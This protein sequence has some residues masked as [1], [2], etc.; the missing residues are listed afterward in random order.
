M[1]LAFLSSTS[2]S[3]RRA[4][5]RFLRIALACQARGHAIRVYTLEW[6]GDVP[7][8]FEVVRVPVGR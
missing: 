6:T 1:Q 5:A 8:G 4:A 7:A 2:I 3:L